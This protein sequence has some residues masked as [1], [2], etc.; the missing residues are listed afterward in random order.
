M[1]TSKGQIA[2]QDRPMHGV[3][4]ICRFL[5][6]FCVG[7]STLTLVQCSSETNRDVNM[8]K[9]PMY[10][11]VQ[12]IEPPKAREIPKELIAHGHRRV[13]PYYWLNQRDAPEVLDYLEAE[14]R[15]YDQVT[16]HLKPFEDALFQEM[17]ARIPQRDSSVPYF[18][19]GYFY[20]HHYD[21]GQ[22][23]PQY[24][25]M[26][27]D[28]EAPKELLLDVNALAEGHDYYQ[29]G[30]YAVS[31]DNQLLAFSED[32][33]GR[34]IYRIRF[35][36][37]S[38]GKFLDDVLEN[39]SGNVVW[40]ADNRTVFYVVK[41]EVTLRPYRVMRH[42]LGTP[43]SEDV[44]VFVEED[45]T[46][47]TYVY[48]TKTEKYIVIGSSA[49]LSDEYRFIPADQP[50][51]SFRIFHPRERGLEYEIFHD[52][53]RW[54][55][56]T[57]WQAEN[58]RL[59]ATAED[60]TTKEH[61]YEIVPHHP[62]QL[63]ENVEP[64]RDFIVLV[65][66]VEAVKRIQILP[67]SDTTQGHYVDFGE[68]VHTAWLDV[69]TLYDTDVVRIG[70]TSL[71]TP[72]TIYDYDMR[73]RQ[74][75]LLKRRKVV[76]GYDPA[77]YISERIWVEARDGVR[78]PVSLVYPKGWKRDGSSPLLLYGYGSYGIS[79]DPHFSIARLSL[80]ERGFAY[81][82]AHVRGGQELG[83]QWYENGK[84]L[85]KKNTFT[86]FIDC[87]EYLVKHRYTSADRLFAMGGS[88]GGLLMG[89]VINMRPDLWKGVVAAVPFVDVLTTMLDESIPLTTG[90][91]DEWGNP[92][93]REYYFYILSYS[94]YD[95][96][97]QQAYPALFVTTGYH[98]SQVQYWE[99]AK[100]VAKLRKY[101]TDNN[102]LLFYCDM[103]TGHSGASGRFKQYRDIARE[104]AFILD[105]AGKAQSNQTTQ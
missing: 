95:N 9:S 59:M 86:D 53:D 78:V 62:Q 100:W 83:R 77:H 26:K 104:Y 25:R 23:F 17:T 46:F 3:V 103:S 60:A 82:I 20:Q 8:R 39:T 2:E 66:R 85:K 10:K 74:L 36:D 12:E 97:Q 89:A 13:D 54:L 52:G 32:T 75:K 27:G 99:P 70:F 91:Y 24:Y 56:L 51:V 58:F 35:K 93:E 43:Q 14:N 41:D 6:I 76:G 1:A 11:R 63:I 96:V 92:N 67:K 4:Y 16:E 90:E 47:Y 84:L 105:L 71:T 80:L 57:N 94:P 72:N 64:F 69:N 28:V 81:A 55:I 101:K 33:L 45:E 31:P 68:E 15:Y 42:R 98:D 40:A 44:E 102:P 49:T 73:K 5:W 38:T 88:A 22:E 87:A 21:E 50:K 19:R 79:I 65:K 30:S 48:K 18:K 37:L 61:W 7:L 34:R 29:L